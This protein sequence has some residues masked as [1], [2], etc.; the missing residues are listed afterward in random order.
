MEITVSY[1]LKEF[2]QSS[3]RDYLEALRIYYEGT[4]T[5]LKTDTNEISYWL[6]QYNATFDDKLF[7][8]GFYENKKVI[9]FA[10]LVY[11][12]LEK[13]I[14]VDY[15]TIEK[16]YRGNN[17]FFQFIGCLKQFINKKRLDY[18]YIVTEIGYLSNN[19]IPSVKSAALIRLLKAQNFGVIKSLYYQPRLG[20]INHES[21]MKAFLLIY[22]NS[23]LKE[24]KK[25]TFLQIVNTIYYKH[26]LR[27]YQSFIDIKDY[28]ND[29]DA[30]YRRIENSIE[31]K[32]AIQINGI[33]FEEAEIK[34]PPK[35][36]HNWIGLVSS[37]A[38][39]IILFAIFV[40]SQ[41]ALQINTISVVS[42]FLLSLITMVALIAIFMKSKE[43][44]RI[45]DKLLN[46]FKRIS[47]KIK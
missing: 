14:V 37:L 47:G 22:T 46:S 43:A 26:Y 8:F 7:I 3:D 25:E 29:L 19:E 17:N 28:K 36:D 9:G 38:L 30:T 34:E 24:I 44:A 1:K 31:K 15:L 32:K 39:V 10:Q 41:V 35:Q 5:A 4:P 27:W 42:L 13:I 33:R 2:E 21:D 6:D 20:E 16:K 40:Y 45:F 18:N 11:F 12:K 23:P